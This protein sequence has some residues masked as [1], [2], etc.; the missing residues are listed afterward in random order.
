MSKQT[1]K[2]ISKKS[3]VINQLTKLFLPLARTHTLSNTTKAWC[4]WWVMSKIDK[5]RTV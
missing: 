5:Q 1:K 2:Y 3:I 4:F